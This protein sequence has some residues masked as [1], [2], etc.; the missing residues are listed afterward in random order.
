MNDEFIV[1]FKK[2]ILWGY[3][4]KH[5]DKIKWDCISM[6]QKLSQSFIEKYIDKFNI[7]KII[8]YQDVSEEFIEKYKDTYKNSDIK[9]I[10]EE[11]IYISFKLQ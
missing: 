9:Y 7:T 10:D 1:K 6:F 5:K 11:Y 8:K 4:E 2:Y 3:I